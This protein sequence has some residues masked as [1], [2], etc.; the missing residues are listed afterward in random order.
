VNDPANIRGE[1]K[2]RN[3][4]IRDLI[5]RPPRGSGK[6]KDKRK[7]NENRSKNTPV[8]DPRHS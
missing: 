3:P 7:Q 5:Q 1:V 6:H 2:K 8:H 4:V